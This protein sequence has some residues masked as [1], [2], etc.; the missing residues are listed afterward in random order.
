MAEAWSR[1]RSAGRWRW[2]APSQTNRPCARGFAQGCAACL[3]Y[4]SW[5]SGPERRA[6][7]CRHGRRRRRRCG[8]EVAARNRVLGASMLPSSLKS[9]HKEFKRRDAEYVGKK[10]EDKVLI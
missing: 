8:E 3:R 10:N 7:L 5:R 6:E 4:G 9:C 1:A 2:R